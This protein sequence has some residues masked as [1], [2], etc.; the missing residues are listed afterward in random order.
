[1]E[2]RRPLYKLGLQI[3]GVTM[4]AA[5]ALV[6]VVWLF[7]DAPSNAVSIIAA[8]LGVVGLSGIALLI[9]DFAKHGAATK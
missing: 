8:V 2:A 9:I 6:T 4:L 3:C 7:L 1:M 5:L